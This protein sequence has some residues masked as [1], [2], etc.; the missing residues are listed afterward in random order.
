MGEIQVRGPWVIQA[1]Y[2]NPESADRFT[3]D[4]WFR[5][6]DVATVDPEGYVQITDRT[7]DLIKSGG[8][9]ISSIDV[10][11]MIMGHPKVLEAAVI[12]VAHPKWVERPL[13]CVVPEARV[14]PAQPSGDHRLPSAPAG[15]VGAARRGRPARR[16]AQD[17]RGQVRQE[18]PATS[19]S[20]TGR[21]RRECGIQTPT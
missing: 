13:A 10:E 6:G 1:Y 19:A 7:K 14:G 12:A 18:G 11:T 21:R 3:A 16:G 20:R 4:G 9:W 5:T 8:E 2:D 17:Q 15:E